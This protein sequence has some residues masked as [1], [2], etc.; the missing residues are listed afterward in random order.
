MTEVAPAMF[1]I[2]AM[3]TVRPPPLR[4]MT[5]LSFQAVRDSEDE[6]R[7]RN[8]ETLLHEGKRLSGCYDLAERASRD[9]VRPGAL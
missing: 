4:R 2:R 3:A 1:E 7:G 5:P 8:E 6:G 9:T